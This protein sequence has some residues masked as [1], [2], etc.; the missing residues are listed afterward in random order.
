MPEPLYDP[1]DHKPE[2]EPVVDEVASSVTRDAGL[3]PWADF[4]DAPP[5]KQ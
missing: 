3:D 2:G 4:E 5:A 1:E